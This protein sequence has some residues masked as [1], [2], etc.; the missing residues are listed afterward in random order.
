M[1]RMFLLTLPGL[2]L[3]GPREIHWTRFSCVPIRV[4]GI[5][6]VGTQL[7]LRKIVILIFVYVSGVF[8]VSDL[9]LSVP[10]LF[11]LRSI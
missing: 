2:H 4:L 7:N 1:V 5:R 9:S 11:V 3:T 10:F 6:R 8:L